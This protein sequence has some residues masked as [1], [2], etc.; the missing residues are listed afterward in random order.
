MIITKGLRIAR[1]PGF[2]ERLAEFMPGFEVYLQLDSLKRDAL[3][4]LRGADLSKVR[5][6]A[7][8]AL[9]RAGVST[10]LVVTVKKGVNDAEIPELVRFALEWSCVRGVTFQPIQD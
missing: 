7:L 6:Q 8:E 2:A 10:T 4:D 3:L 9:E 1:E 5:I